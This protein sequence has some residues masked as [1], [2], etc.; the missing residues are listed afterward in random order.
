VLSY[1]RHLCVR[2]SYDT[3][4][5]SFLAGHVAAF[6]AFGGVP[7][8]VLYDHVARHIIVVLLPG[9]LCSR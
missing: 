7:R 2:F 5:P 1:S 3:R 8:C 4:L 6:T 9:A